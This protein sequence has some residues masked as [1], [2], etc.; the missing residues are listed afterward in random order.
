MKL[1]EEAVEAICEY[2]WKQNHY[3]YKNVYEYLLNLDLVFTSPS[4]KL[5]TL[6][7]LSEERPIK[8]EN[9]D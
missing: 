5:L 4:K 8:L 7:S 2:I 6:E 3:A 9:E 1:S